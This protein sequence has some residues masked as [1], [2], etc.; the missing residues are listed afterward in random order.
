MESRTAQA[1]IAGRVVALRQAR[2]ASQQDLADRLTEIGYPKL[3]RTALSKLEKCAQRITVE[4]LL[5][6]AVALDVAPVVL[7]T[8]QEGEALDVVPTIT[9]LEAADANPWLKG[10]EPIPGSDI[11][12][13]SRYAGARG[14]R[15]DL[16]PAEPTRA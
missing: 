11:E 7:L 1:V 5:A 15:R 8:P 3:H 12:S 6:L 16:G 2:G 10:W 13:R 9:P 4:D 14:D